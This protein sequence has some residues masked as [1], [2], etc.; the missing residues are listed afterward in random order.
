MK[1]FISGTDIRGYADGDNFDKPNYLSDD[2]V[3]AITRGFIAWL[4]VKGTPRSVAVGNDSRTSAQRLKTAVT[5][6]LTLHGIDVFDCGLTST[7]SMFRAVGGLKCDAS[8]MLTA[9]HHPWDRNGLKFFTSG[10]GLEHADIESILALTN[11]P[12]PAAERLGRITEVRYIDEYSS[13]LRAMICDALGAE[14]GAKPLSGLK[15]AVDAGNGA[16]GFYAEKVLKPLGVDVSGSVFLEPDGSFPNHIPNPE[17]AAA[18]Q[19]ISDATVSSDSDLGVIFDTDVDRAACVDKT[20]AEFSRSRLVALASAV[21]LENVKDGIIVTDSIASDGAEK[22]VSEHLGAKL[23]L[24]KRGYKNVI[25]EQKRLNAEGKS[26]PLAIETSGHAAFAENDYLD[27]GAYLVT[28]LIIK[29]AQLAQ[30]GKTLADLISGMEE[31]Q[32]E[33]ELRAA[34]TADDFRASGEEMLSALKKDQQDKPTR[35]VRDDSH[36]GV[37]INFSENGGGWFVVRMSVH[38]PVVPINI[39][40]STREGLLAIVSELCDFIGGFGDFDVGRLKD[41]LKAVTA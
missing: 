26:C 29:A 38:D 1:Q 27:D 4:S 12:I 28:R 10:G 19:A 40:C 24:F 5:D 31:L 32:F 6:E 18:M 14:E 2:V 23:E 41:Y 21:A 34:I 11:S 9:S 22:F 15:I 39:E 25:N 8:I 36:E 30:S 33:T 16:G 35:R 17:N 13:S 3:R 20:G 7:P 37:R